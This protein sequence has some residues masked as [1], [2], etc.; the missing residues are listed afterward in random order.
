[1]VAEIAPREVV[2]DQVEIFAVL[3]GIV[4]IDDED[5]V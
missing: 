1:M 4:H 5:V 3:K 2:H